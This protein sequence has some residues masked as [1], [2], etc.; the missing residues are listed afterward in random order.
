M[1][2]HVLLRAP[3]GLDH[4]LVPGDV[5]G[6]LS[7]AALPID[8]GRVSEAHAMVSLRDGALRLLPLRGAFAMDGKPLEQVILEAGQEI[9]LARGVSLRVISV[10]LPE[11]VLGLE[12]PGLPLRALPGVASLS[13]TPRIRVVR[14]W[15]ARAAVQLWSTGDAWRLRRPGGEV[16]EVVP[17]DEVEVD[18]VVFTFRAMPL[19]GAGPSATRRGD[20]LSAPLVLVANYETVH[21]QRQDRVVL[22]LS[23]IL[24]RIASELVSFGGPVGWQVLCGELWPD[25]PDAAVVRARL[26]ANLSRLRRK[27]RAAGVRTDLVR[28]DG[29]GQVELLLYPQ[30]RVEDR[31]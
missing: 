16:R 23:G 1:H 31:T 27:L 6:R 10:A 20:G 22:K 2:P 21:L 3:D 17:G 7:T 19:S 25:E 12:G 8:D 24:A 28:T 11:E 30:D 4:E 26:D 15:D 9:S 13:S 29:A 5:I 18:G 14:G